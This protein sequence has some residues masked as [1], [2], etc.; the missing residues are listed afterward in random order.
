MWVASNWKDYQLLDCGEGKRYE[1]WGKQ[2]LVRPDPQAIWEPAQKWNKVNAVYHRSNTG[3]GSWEVF[4]LPEQ[5]QISYRNTITFNIN[6]YLSTKIFAHLR[7]QSD[8]NR[9]EE[10]H[11]HKWQFKEILS[12]GFSYRFSRA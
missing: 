12:I 5:W 10:T 1:R 8:A 2:L 3:G 7:Y 9:F 11:W 4:N 6:K